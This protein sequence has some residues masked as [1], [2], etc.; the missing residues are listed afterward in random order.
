MKTADEMFRMLGYKPSEFED[1]YIKSVNDKN[2]RICI[3]HGTPIAKWTY[4]K[5]GET[6]WIAF[7]Q[8]EVIA[9]AQLIREMEDTK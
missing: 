7:T 8:E 4:D 6:V 2:I 1:V 9:C 5:F 3:G